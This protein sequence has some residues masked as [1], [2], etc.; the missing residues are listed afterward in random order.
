MP[1]A[2]KMRESLKSPFWKGYHE[3]SAQYLT[4]LKFR[5]REIPIE[6]HI[7]DLWKQWRFQEGKCAY[8][9][10]VL[11]LVK[12]D[13]GW[14]KSTASLDRKDSSKGYIK[15]NIQW[16]HKAINRMKLDLPEEAF[17]K[18]CKLVAGHCGV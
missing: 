7:E 6:V 13:T 5:K 17:I 1:C 18:Y 15:E 10:I 8:T 9:G 12:K 14:S 2:S 11:S 16:V 3:M 4:R